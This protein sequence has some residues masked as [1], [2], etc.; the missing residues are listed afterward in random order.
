[1]ARTVGPEARPSRDQAQQAIGDLE[2]V[3]R[4]Y[5]VEAVQQGRRVQG[6]FR[7]HG[8]P[9]IVAKALACPAPRRRRAGPRR[10]TPATPV[11]GRAA[12]GGVPPAR[13][14]SPAYCRRHVRVVVVGAMGVRRE[15]Q[16][17]PLSQPIGIDEARAVADVTAEIERGERRPFGPVAQE[18]VCDTPQRVARLHGIRRGRDGRRGRGGVP[19][20]R[21]MSEELGPP[22][23]GALAPAPAASASGAPKVVTASTPKAMRAARRSRTDEP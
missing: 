9:Y 19:G 8:S 11:R 5:T 17:P 14:A 21:A 15:P 1:M 7:W 16:A 23:T 18:I 4:R 22:P 6:A 20:R 10:R 12:R 2:R 13:G 3:E